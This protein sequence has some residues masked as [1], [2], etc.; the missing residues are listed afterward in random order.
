MAE[1]PYQNKP[2]NQTICVTANFMRRM[3]LTDSLQ[4]CLEL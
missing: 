1:K 4:S 3:G 2:K